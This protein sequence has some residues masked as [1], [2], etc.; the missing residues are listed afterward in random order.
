MLKYSYIKLKTKQLRE[1]LYADNNSG[2]W[3]D[4]NK[5]DHLIFRRGAHTQQDFSQQI[6]NLTGSEPHPHVSAVHFTR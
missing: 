3:K 1:N 5:T 6:L 4:T 2:L